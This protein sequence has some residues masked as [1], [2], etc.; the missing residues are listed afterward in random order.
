[1]IAT[2][3]DMHFLMPI[4]WHLLFPWSKSW[5]ASIWP[6]D[7]SIVS[8]RQDPSLCNSTYDAYFLDNDTYN[9]FGLLSS[10]QV[11]IH[12]WISLPCQPLLSGYNERGREPYASFGYE[13]RTEWTIS[14]ETSW[15]ITRDHFEQDSRY[16]VAFAWNCKNS[17]FGDIQCGTCLCLLWKAGHEGIQSGGKIKWI[18]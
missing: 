16:Q 14:I 13:T 17:R 10:S 8:C 9:R 1:M 6:M 18:N 15:N 4:S 7:D 12:I 3:A 11:M 5:I 2:N